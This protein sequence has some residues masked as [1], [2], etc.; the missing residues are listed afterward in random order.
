MPPLGSIGSAALTHLNMASVKEHAKLHSAAGGD[1]DDDDNL[2]TQSDDNLSS[3]M[4]VQS[5]E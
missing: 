1:R 4:A 3:S 5:D 2:S